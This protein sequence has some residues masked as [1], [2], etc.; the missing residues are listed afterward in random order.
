MTTYRFSGKV[1][2][3]REEHAFEREVEAESIN[4]AEDKV[5]AEL[6]SEHSINRSKIEIN[7]SEEA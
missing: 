2:L 4:Q 6:G 5:Y 1:Q 7:E 3:G